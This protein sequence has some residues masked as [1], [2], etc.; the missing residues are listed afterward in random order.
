MLKVNS[1]LASENVSFLLVVKWFHLMQC[2]THAVA[3]LM[4]PW[5]SKKV[6]LFPGSL[7]TLRTN[8]LPF[9]VC[10]FYF[11]LSLNPVFQ[12]HPL[13]PRVDLDSFNV[14]VSYLVCGQ[15]FRLWP[16]KWKLLSKCFPVPLFIMLYT[17]VS[18]FWVCGSIL[19]C[20]HSNESFWVVL[21]CGAV[22]YAVQGVYFLTFNSVDVATDEIPKWDHSNESYWAVLSRGAVYCV[23]QDDSNFWAC[24]WN[25]NVS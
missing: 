15:N 16:F 11:P 6:F 9:T 7:L 8:T 14:F 13:S 2:K 24:G 25:P 23:A 12:Q 10:R 21:S 22:Y 17:V 5:A 4:W 18:N 3:L 1:K 20:D 19:N